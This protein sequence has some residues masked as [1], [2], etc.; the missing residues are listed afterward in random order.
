MAPLRQRRVKHGCLRAFCWL[1]PT[2]TLVFAAL[3][4]IKVRHEALRA[5]EPQDPG[6]LASIF[7]CITFAWQVDK[8]GLLQLVRMPGLTRLPTHMRG[9]QGCLSNV[10]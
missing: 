2:F 3:A 5:S 9:A 1:L 7:V 10:T 6:P 8:L 4:G